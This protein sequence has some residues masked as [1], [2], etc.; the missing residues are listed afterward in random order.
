[1]S[2]I[3]ENSIET[4]KYNVTLIHPFVLFQLTGFQ[5]GL[6]MTSAWVNIETLS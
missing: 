2:F 4:Q 5:H 6:C 1:M 3:P